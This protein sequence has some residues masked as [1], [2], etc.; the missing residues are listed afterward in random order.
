MNNNPI[1]DN[2]NELLRAKTLI[3]ESQ[4]L[5]SNP[6]GFEKNIKEA[7]EILSTLQTEQI[8]LKDT[9]ELLMKIEAL[10][11]EMYD[12]QT[13]DLTKKKSIISLNPSDISPIQL[14]EYNKKY[15]LYGK[16][17]A[18]I[19]V[20][21]GNPSPSIKKYQSTEDVLSVDTTEDGTPV[22]L[23]DSNRIITLRKNEFT[24]A[25]VT[26]QDGWEEA[27]IIKTFNG[28]IYL[29]NTKDGNIWKHRP[30]MNG[31]SQKSPVFEGTKPGILDIAID[32]G[33]YIVRYDGKIERL[34]SGKGEFPIVLNKIP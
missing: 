8:Y 17:S 6:Q 13:V 3:E 7:S 4:K 10:K 15:T 12:I 30:G 19:E 33:F 11:K 14:Y 22:L 28:N 18:Y 20:V 31:Y 27:D 29:I 34:I 1:I 32:G 9:Q 21:P 24:Y 25:S 23:T 16:R 5:I 26:G 2:R